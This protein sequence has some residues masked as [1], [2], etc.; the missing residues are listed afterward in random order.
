[1]ANVKWKPEWA[2]RFNQTLGRYE[3]EIE[4]GVWVSRQRAWQLAVREIGRCGR[5]GK[6]RGV[7]KRV[8]VACK[9]YLKGQKHKGYKGKER[10]HAA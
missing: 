6:K 2:R 9:E 3:V 5:C 1:M 7:E 8:C 4:P 10:S